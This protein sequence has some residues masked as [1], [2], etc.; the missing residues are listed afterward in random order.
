MSRV[1]ARLLFQ[2][3]SGLSCFLHFSVTETGESDLSQYLPPLSLAETLNKLRD[4]KV[5]REDVDSAFFQGSVLIINITLMS[6]NV[7]YVNNSGC[8]GLAQCD[9][10][11][12]PTC[13]GA[14]VNT[15]VPHAEAA[16]QE[17]LPAAEEEPGSCCAGRREG[18][19]LA[20][21]RRASRTGGVRSSSAEREG[22]EKRKS[23]GEEESNGGPK[24]P[25]SQEA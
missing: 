1:C 4:T 2:V 8:D 6:V 21:G 12:N 15:P 13:A 23:R 24:T 11:T 5:L 20:V 9:P 22:V 7:I 3:S 25:A 18:K 14:V 19:K 16:K 17:S 10:F